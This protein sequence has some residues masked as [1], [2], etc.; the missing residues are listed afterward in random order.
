LTHSPR[1]II[2][3]LLLAVSVLTAAGC[4]SSSGSSS[5]SGS[6][7]DAGAPLK[8]NACALFNEQDAQAIAGDTLAVMSSTMEDAHGHNPLECIYNSGTLEE[9]RILSLLVRQHRSAATAKDLQGSSRAPL[10]AMAGGKVADV[11]GLGDGAL[12]F[13][14]KLQQL[15]VLAGSRQLLVTVQSPD[16]SDQ[17]PRARQIATRALERLTAAAQAA[18]GSGTDTGKKRG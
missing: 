7:Q 10:A 9:P 6:Q 15:H 16:G 3:L 2:A 17:L 14:G 1:R 12:W 5:G 8:I 18:A 4:G 11:P 13:G